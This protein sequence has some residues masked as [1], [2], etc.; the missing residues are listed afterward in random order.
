VAGVIAATDNGVGV[1]G[2]APD[3]DLWAVRVLDSGGSGSTSDVICGI[4][5]V[6]SKSPAK[7]GPSPWPT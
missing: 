4:D 5:F 7:G 2:V 6:D 3:A 1:V